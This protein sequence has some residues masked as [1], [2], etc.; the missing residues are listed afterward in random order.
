VAGDLKETKL[1]DGVYVY[2]DD[3]ELMA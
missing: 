1:K 3:G 2:A